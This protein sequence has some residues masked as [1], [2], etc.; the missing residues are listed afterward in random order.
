MNGNITM[1]ETCDMKNTDS[2]LTPWSR[3]LL[4]KLTGSQLVKKYPSFC[5]TRKFFAEFTSAHHPSL[6]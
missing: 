1:M 5:G 4:E 2:S 6:S 3:I